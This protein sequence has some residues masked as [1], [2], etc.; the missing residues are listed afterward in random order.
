MTTSLEEQLQREAEQ[1]SKDHPAQPSSTSTSA[2]LYYGK[3]AEELFQL[4]DKE[5]HGVTTK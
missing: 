4:S 3:T 5:P 2:Q 1:W